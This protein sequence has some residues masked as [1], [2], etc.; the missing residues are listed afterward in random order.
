[1][2]RSCEYH[3]IVL[4]FGSVKQQ[5]EKKKKER[6]GGLLASRYNSKKECDFFGVVVIL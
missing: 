1:M 5:E 2:F 4:Q 3:G 6:G